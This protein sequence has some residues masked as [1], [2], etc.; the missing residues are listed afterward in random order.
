[1]SLPQP[2]S[3][4]FLF[5]L[6]PSLSLAQSIITGTPLL[7]GPYNIDSSSFLDTTTHTGTNISYPIK[8]F[9]TS[10]PA[11]A[12]SG[13]GNSVP[14]WSLNIGI[15][16]DVSLSGSNSQDATKFFQAT[17]ISII[18]PS[19]NQAAGIERFNESNWRVCALVFTSGLGKSETDE[20]EDGVRGDCRDLL[21]SD[22][23]NQLQ[24][25]SVTNVAELG[26]GCQGIITMPTVC[27]DHFAARGGSDV[28]G[29]EL[30][31]IS[32]DVK[33]NVDRR[34]TFF[35]AGSEAVDRGNKTALGRAQRKVWPVLLV[36]THFAGDGKVHDSQGG[37]S[38]VKG[39]KTVD[40]GDD[41]GGDHDGD[42]GKDSGASLMEV[43]G[44]KMMGSLIGAAAVAF[45]I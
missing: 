15:T 40:D 5:L 29:F 39:V 7:S 14:G 3:S 19:R 6:L 41:D 12:T 21:P 45:A 43:V 8:G 16:P 2:C 33:P 37:L 9:N 27:N 28:M 17:T 22:C 13:T 38:C 11:G 18:P 26:G 30:L 44:W 1:M 20:A 25:N 42:D 31:P 34:S 24:V 36:W 10:I 32:G 4:L 23:V 35:A